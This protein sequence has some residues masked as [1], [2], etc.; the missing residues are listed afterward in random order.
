MK[1]LFIISLVL[2]MLIV[3]SGVASAQYWFKSPEFTSEVNYTREAINTAGNTVLVTDELTFK[4]QIVM[5][6]AADT[7]AGA[8]VVLIF[9]CGTL[10]K[11]TSEVIPLM[12]ALTQSQLG[13][14]GSHHVTQ[15]TVAHPE[16]LPILGDGTFYDQSET[17][18]TGICTIAVAGIANDSKTA[19]ITGFTLT[20]DFEGAYVQGSG[21]AGNFVSHTFTTELT[22]LTLTDGNTSVTCV[23]GVVTQQ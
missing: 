21:K 1:K 11:G 16:Q 2:G 14:I 5:E 7:W 6:T 22:P 23:D 12:C 15:S 10:Y 19:F 4:G 9:L 17:P 3:F 8:P 18:T 13:V 20:G